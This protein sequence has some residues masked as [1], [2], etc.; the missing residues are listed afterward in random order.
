MYDFTFLIN[1]SCTVQIVDS[2]FEN[3]AIRAKKLFFNPISKFR[4]VS[5]Y[6]RG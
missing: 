3:A 5:I 6:E 2:N 1:E 4:L